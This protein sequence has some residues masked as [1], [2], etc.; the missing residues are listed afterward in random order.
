MH[1]T[2]LGL[3]AALLCVPV[4][5]QL[6]TNATLLNTP[7][8]DT[9]LGPVNLMVGEVGQ[10]ELRP[11]FSVGPNVYRLTATVSGGAA[12]PNGTSPSG[13]NDP[14]ECQVDFSTSPP[15]FSNWDYSSTA[16]VATAGEEFQAS[17]TLDLSVI[18]TDYDY[19]GTNPGA[20]I[21]SRSS[22]AWNP[23]LNGG[24]GGYPPFGNRTTITG[25]PGGAIDPHLGRVNGQYYLYYVDLGGNISRG[26]ID[27]DPNSPNFGAVTGNTVVL[28]A[29]NQ[30]NHSPNVVYDASGRAVAFTCSNYTG[31]SGSD[32][33]Y[34]Y[35]TGAEPAGALPHHMWGDAVGSNLPISNWLAN[36]ASIGGQLYYANAPG[37][38]YVEP[39]NIQVVGTGTSDSVSASA[40]GT[41][42]A[43]LVSPPSSSPTDLGIVVLGTPLPTP[44][45]IFA[46]AALQ[47][48]A[49][50]VQLGPLDA[51]GCFTVAVPIAPG[52]PVT[53]NV[54][55]QAG[56][57]QPATNTITLAEPG[58]V[59]IT[60]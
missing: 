14:F 58:T 7:M 47:V 27:V 38:T 41:A 8:P 34:C 59:H 53:G 13:G 39:M 2:L 57:F 19:G 33:W 23:S 18:V 10:Y 21:A 55:A 5:A 36:P 44:L 48:S 3:S 22:T 16:A 9:D 56:L 49:I 15:T 37:G 12:L 28:S 46:G 42:V 29:Q 40:G 17:Q 54:A 1:K 50:V 51:N 4:S 24:A 11:D 43:A 60:P 6:A 20:Q 30:F 52:F 35:W 31:T 32:A 26:A 25:V 45:P